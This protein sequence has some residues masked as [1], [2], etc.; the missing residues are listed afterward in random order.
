MA[1]ELANLVLE[2]P[3]KGLFNSVKNAV[4]RAGKYVGKGLQ[5]ALLTVM[6]APVALGVS[7]LA[8]CKDPFIPNSPPTAK[9]Y[10]INPN[11]GVAPFS[12]QIKYI[13]EDPDGEDDIIEQSVFADY[14]DNRE[15]N[16][17]ETIIGPQ[18]RSIN[19]SYTFTTPGTFSVYGRAVD[20]AGHEIQTKIG[21]ISVLEPE[22]PPVEPPVEPPIDPP[23]EPPIEPPVE[24][25]DYLDVS[26][27]VFNNESTNPLFITEAGRRAK[28]KVFDSADETTPLDGILQTDASGNLVYTSTRK[29]SEL[30]G[31]TLTAVLV[32]ENGNP[33][34]YEHTLRFPAGDL[35]S[36]I[37]KPHPNITFDTNGDGVVN[38]TDYENYR[39]HRRRI[40]TRTDIYADDMKEAGLIKFDWEGLFGIGVLSENPYGG[41]FSHEVPSGKT[42]FDRI[43]EKIEDSNDIEVIARG[44]NLADSDSDGLPDLDSL[45]LSTLIEGTHYQKIGNDIYAKPGYVIFVPY[46]SL[47]QNGKEVN[48]LIT[49]IWKNE[50]SLTGIIVGATIRIRSLNNSK[51]ETTVSHESTHLI[52]PYD[53]PL[54]NQN[55]ITYDAQTLGGSNSPPNPDLTILRYDTSLIKPGIADKED[56]YITNEEIYPPRVK[57]DDILSIPQLED[58]N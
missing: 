10:S 50:S 45:V 24:D 3:K 11:S 18:Q 34:S 16:E 37:L 13:V 54:V 29:V 58:W 40:N 21:D 26:L 8:G 30:T 23:E 44:S 19:T 27:Q 47:T 56:A 49:P 7:S 42:Q 33:I 22:E 9:E 31:V 46:D 57:L 2:P 35:T 38:Q 14:N 4:S 39:E 41:S 1:K 25:N 51:F 52:D 28:V 36:V 53:L 43:I 20:S 48:G 32:D 55:P 6:M 5:N 15:E 12:S 17:E